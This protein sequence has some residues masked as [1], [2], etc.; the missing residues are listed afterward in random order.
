MVEFALCCALL[1]LA[2]LVPWGGGQ[3][4][5]NQLVLALR[6]YMRVLVLLVSIS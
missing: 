5:L 1:T 3:P 6:D 4:A 2:L